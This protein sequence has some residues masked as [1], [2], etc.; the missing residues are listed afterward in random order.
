MSGNPPDD[1]ISDGDRDL[2]Q[3]TMRTLIDALRERGHNSVVINANYWDSEAERKEY[4]DLEVHLG[5]TYHP[6]GDVDADLEWTYEH[7]YEGT[8]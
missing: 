6:D 7:S 1:A 2:V 8:L 5:H 4:A 3:S